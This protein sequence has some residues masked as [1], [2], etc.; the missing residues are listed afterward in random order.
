MKLNLANP[1]TGLQKDLECDDEKVLRNFYDK[2]ISQE[3]DGGV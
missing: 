1:S 3:I 2:R